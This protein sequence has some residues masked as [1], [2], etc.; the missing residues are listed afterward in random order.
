M[1]LPPTIRAMALDVLPLH[2][3]NPGPMTGD[4]NWTYLIPG[5]APVLVDAGAGVPVHLDRVMDHAPGGPALV[6]VTHAHH[7]HIGGVPALTA[8]SPRTRFAKW[9]WPERDAR[10][11]VAFD[12]VADARMVPTGSGPLE[13][14]HTPGHAPDHV[15]LWHAAS[16]TV[17]A[18]DLLVQTGTVVIP[19]SSGGSLSAYLASLA[20]VA[21]L[22]PARALPAH[23]P[24][25]EEPLALIAH[26][27]AHRRRR[28][29]QILAALDAG[30][31]LIPGIVALLYRGLDPA[32]LPMAE[33]GVLAHLVK[34][35]D[36]GHVAR[37][38]ERWVLTG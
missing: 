1:G 30:E 28:E 19:A 14:V 24:P 18:G 20:R 12:A 7:D 35:S 13:V 8:R 2:A 23:G 33:E 22:E 31:H 29:Q 6:V 5:T 25:I 16:R 10:Y 27:L 26:Y 38:G 9:P 34:L 15:V 17:F 4:G 37:R 32:L 36:D 21:A 11:G 3:A